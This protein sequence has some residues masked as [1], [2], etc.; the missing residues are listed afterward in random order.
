MGTPNYMVKSTKVCGDPRNVQR[1]TAY[2]FAMVELRSLQSS[3]MDSQRER[4]LIS[5]DSRDYTMPGKSNAQQSK[6]QRE[7][8][9]T[10]TREPIGHP[11]CPVFIYHV[12]TCSFN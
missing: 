9:N 12:G 10:C 8:L 1:C 5:K 6:P 11:P 7:D 3:V 4:I 2:M